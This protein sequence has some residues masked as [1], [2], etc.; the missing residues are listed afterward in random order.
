MS[1]TQNNYYPT[2]TG[3]QERRYPAENVQDHEKQPFYFYGN[4]DEYI[5]MN[6]IEM[7]IKYLPDKYNGASKML[8]DNAD[9]LFNYIKNNNYA[10]NK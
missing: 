6:C 9:R 1:N 10:N 5:R 4:S 7:L 3:C 2:T 8:F